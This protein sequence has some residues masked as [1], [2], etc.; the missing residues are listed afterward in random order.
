MAVLGIVCL[1]AGVAT[2]ADAE[3][4]KKPEATKPVVEKGLSLSIRPAR[5]TFEPGKPVQVDV[6]LKNE[7]DQPLVLFGTKGVSG[8]RP[9]TLT[10][11][12]K[13]VGGKTEHTLREGH[14][15]RIMAPM[16]FGPKTIA[17]GQEIV[18]TCT[19]NQW[20]W[21]R[22]KGHVKRLGAGVLGPGTWEVT[23][24][25]KGSQMGGR[26]WAGTITSNAAGVQVAEKKDE[27]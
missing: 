13:Q 6:L 4:E 14:N 11:R 12:F 26:G 7:T 20:A 8:W 19:I 1:A 18:V 16:A 10:F 2:G 23:V 17:A 25:L 5:T 27:P 3:A 15:P 21:W 24:E 22:E 9:A